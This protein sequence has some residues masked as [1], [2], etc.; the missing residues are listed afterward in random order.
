MRMYEAAGWR[1]E[2]GEDQSSLNPA[3][4][5]QPSSVIAARHHKYTL[6]LNQ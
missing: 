2:R 5:C 3:L 1:Q 6:G 4:K